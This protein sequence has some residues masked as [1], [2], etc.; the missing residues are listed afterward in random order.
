MGYKDSENLNKRSFIESRACESAYL[1]IENNSTIRQVAKQMGCSK[2]TV[3]RDFTKVLPNVDK[4]L[5]I[6]TR[7]VLNTNLVERT[8]RGGQSTKLRYLKE[9]HEKENIN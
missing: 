8:A 2:S 1:L 4:D 3:H 6:K 7:E 5:Y 9:K